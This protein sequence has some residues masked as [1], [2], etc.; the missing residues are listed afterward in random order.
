MKKYSIPIAVVVIL[1]GILVWHT[2]SVSRGIDPLNTDS[3]E[4][5]R[6]APEITSL[7]QKIREMG[8]DAGNEVY[9]ALMQ[10]YRHI[11]AFHNSIGMNEK[12]RKCLLRDYPD[13]AYDKM[14]LHHEGGIY[15][16][17]GYHL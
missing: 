13:P 3:P 4:Y 1:M 17:W 9:L 16:D 15:E 10:D 14:L 2:T 11:K 12:L 6:L 7:E 8:C 5:L